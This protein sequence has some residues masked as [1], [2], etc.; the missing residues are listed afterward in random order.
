MN[1]FIPPL[2]KE[3]ASSSP[4]SAPV[5]ICRRSELVVKIE[6]DPI[7]KAN[8]KKATYILVWEQVSP[9]IHR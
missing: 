8:N 2:P 5:A 9:Y 3:M 6:G 7:I 1:T 4:N